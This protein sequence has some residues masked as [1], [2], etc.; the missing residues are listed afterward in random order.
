LLRLNHF[1][2]GSKIKKMQRNPIYLIV[3]PNNCQIVE[4]VI[5]KSMLFSKKI[6]KDNDVVNTWCIRRNDSLEDDVDFLSLLIS[7]LKSWG[8]SPSEYRIETNS[9]R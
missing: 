8:I 5:G 4:H 2:K 7:E 6:V 1:K 3:N 9:N